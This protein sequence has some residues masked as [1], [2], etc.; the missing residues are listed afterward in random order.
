MSGNKNIDLL[1]YYF[2]N[3]NVMSSSK[4]DND[5]SIIKKPITSDEF[6]YQIDILK[7]LIVRNFNESKK[8]IELLREKNLN[9]ILSLE[10]LKEKNDKLE[11]E[12]EL[13]KIKPKND[14]LINPISL[15]KE[16]KIVE[17]KYK[18][19]LIYLESLL[20]NPTFIYSSRVAITYKNHNGVNIN[21]HDF[22]KN[23]FLSAYLKRRKLCIIMPTNICH[24][25]KIY[26]S[27]FD[28]HNPPSVPYINTSQFIV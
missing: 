21:T 5:C 14:S 8:E 22:F 7:K 1:T 25:Q 3:P 19:L 10:L 24:D 13:L 17:E 28:V 12:I 23:K 2:I 27:K 26:L 16:D 4:Y 20:S 15:D 18:D 9:M 6:E 11:K